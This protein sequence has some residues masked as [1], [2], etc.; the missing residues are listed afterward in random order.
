MNE[1]PLSEHGARS[2]QDGPVPG[3]TAIEVD[4]EIQFRQLLWLGVGLVGTAVLSGFVVFFLLRGFLQAEHEQAAPPPPMVAV[5]LAVPGPKLL[6]FPER[7]LE[8]VRQL[9]AEQLDSYGWVDAQQGIVRVPIDRAI[10]IVAGT[11]LPSRPSPPPGA[12]G[13]DAAT[14]GTAAAPD[15]GFQPPISPAGAAVPAPQDQA[16]PADP[17][18]APD[19][20]A[21]TPP[22]PGARP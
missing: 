20:P 12:A 11:G 16:P 1:R 19:E 4:R 22:P 13:Q 9:E 7:E 5:P 3:Q 15:S 6:A 21:P 10:E 8:R 14:Q 18:A 2:S 17:G